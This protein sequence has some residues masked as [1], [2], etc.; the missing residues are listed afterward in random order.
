MPTHPGEIRVLFIGGTGTISASVVRECV[1]QGMTVFVL[2]RGNN[3]KR[4]DL[5]ESVTWLK[6]DVK[7][8]NSVSAALAGLHFES[9]LNFLSYNAEDAAAAVALFAPLTSQYIHISTASIYHKPL[10]QVP[11]VES[12]SRHNPFLEYSREKI[13]AE[14]VL[15]S[16]YEQS[17]FPAT[18][19]RPSHTY[20]EANP[21]VPG[22]WTVFD[23]IERG[24][25]IVVPGDGT[26]LW[27]LT[28]AKDFA[29]GLVGLIANQRA[30]GE[31]FH[32]TSQ[33]IY[34]WD[35]IYSIIGDALGVAPKLVHVPSE[36]FPL[37]APDWVWSDL[38]VGDLSHSAIFDT[39]KIS[40]FVPAFSPTATFQR[41]AHELVRWRSEHPE[42]SKPDLQV[43]QVIDRLA[44]GYRGSRDLFTKL[45]PPASA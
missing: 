37:A 34:T 8:P 39:S 27:T 1:A 21:P 9:V 36:F 15:L 33:D 17:G 28:H 25:E 41:Q 20:D 38:I 43:A 5:P 22:G 11:I 12:T 19:V 45:A 3:A 14:D 35:Q 10:L 7:D 13:A 6:G 26:S 29:K 42:E 40:R 31:V 24:Q 23:R 16:A 30:A 32:I 18:I 44:E 2:N 4:R